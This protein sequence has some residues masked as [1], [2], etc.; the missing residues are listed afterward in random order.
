M[1]QYAQF[2]FC[3]QIC[4]AVGTLDPPVGIGLTNHS[5][6]HFSSIFENIEYL[7]VTET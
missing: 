6:G 7:K 2:G 4:S 5:V 1:V 3:M